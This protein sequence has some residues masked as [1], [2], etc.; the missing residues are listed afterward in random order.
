MSY[1]TRSNKSVTAELEARGLP[2]FGSPE[3]QKARLERFKKAEAAQTLLA[4]R[5]AE[6]SLEQLVEWYRQCASRGFEE[7]ANAIHAE[8]L[9]QM[10]RCRRNC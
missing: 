10:H 9:Y 7:D 8:I 4:M 1:N 6:P 2:T 5:N 3:R